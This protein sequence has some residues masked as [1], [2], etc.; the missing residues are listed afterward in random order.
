[1]TNKRK[2]EIFHLLSSSI[3]NVIPDWLERWSFPPPG[4]GEELLGAADL[5]LRD[6]VPLPPVGLPPQ[7]ELVQTVLLHQLLLLL[8]QVEN[9]CKY[10]N[11]I[12]R[13]QENILSLM[14]KCVKT[15]AQKPFSHSSLIY[16]CVDRNLKQFSYLHQYCGIMLNYYIWP[17]E[18]S[19][20][21]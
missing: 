13:G 16:E 9:V 11:F 14:N 12:V 5:G 1:M 18:G 2:I 19:G 10:F 3:S 8:Q 4:H 6:S 15:P 21:L 7:H 17:G 20:G